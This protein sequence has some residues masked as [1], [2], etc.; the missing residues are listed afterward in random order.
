M[1]KELSDSSR[2]SKIEVGLGLLGILSG[3]SFSELI[4]SSN[5][6]DSGALRV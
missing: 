4:T 5:P 6:E 1:N 2:G 3:K